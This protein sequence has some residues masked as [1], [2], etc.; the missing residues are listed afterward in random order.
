VL[1]RS[2]RQLAKLC[3]DGTEL[4]AEARDANATPSVLAAARQM[5]S[6]L[7]PTKHEAEDVLVAFVLDCNRCGR[8]VHWVPGDDCQLGHWAHA[9]PVPDDPRPADPRGGVLIG[10]APPGSLASEG[11][12]GDD[13]LL[14]KEAHRQNLAAQGELEPAGTKSCE[15]SKATRA[16]AACVAMF[17]LTGRKKPGLLATSVTSMG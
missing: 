17:V 14:A 10:P 7:P 5:H 11:P 12:A 8:R 2:A 15:A 1:L 16:A 3:R 13:G 9:E 6:T 4:V